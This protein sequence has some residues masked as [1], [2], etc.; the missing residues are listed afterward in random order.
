MGFNLGLLSMFGV[1][2]LSGIVVN[3]SL[4]MIDLINRE[5]KSGIEL[6]QVLRDCATRRFRPIMLTTLTTFCG[7]LPMITEEEPGKG[8]S[9]RFRETMKSRT[10]E[11][12]DG[13]RLR[14]IASG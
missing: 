3:D 9:L 11:T 10:A 6:S 4:I 5:R 7:L 1:V 14:L 13:H 12:T 8:Y 2:A